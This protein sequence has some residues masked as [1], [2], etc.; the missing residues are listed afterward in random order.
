MHP[1][2]AVV[3]VVTAASRKVRLVK[4]ARAVKP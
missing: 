3:L 1:L 2:E 4:G